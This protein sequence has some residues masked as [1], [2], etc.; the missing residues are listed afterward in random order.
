MINDAGIS[1]VLTQPDLAG[2]LPSDS[3]QLIVDRETLERESGDNHDVK[4]SDQ[5]LAYVLYTSG[6]TGK[7]K[8]VEVQHES[9]ATYAETAILNFEVESTDRVLQFASISFDTSAEEIYSCLLS[10][11]TLVL[12]SDAML[13]SA[14]EFFRQCDKWNITV[15]DL[16]TAYW[17]EL[18][19]AIDTISLPASLRLVILGGEKVRP[20]YVSRWRERCGDHP[21]LCNTYGP[22]EATIVA[23]MFDFAESGSFENAPIGRPIDHARVRVL[24]RSLRE[25]PIGISGELYIGGAGLARGYRNHP[26]LTAERF[27]PDPF[28]ES[29][30]RLYKSGDVVRWLPDGNLDYV[31]RLDKQ[32][33]IRGFRVETGEI[34]TTLREH[35]SVSDVVVVPR[36]EENDT[37]LVAYVLTNGDA[38]EPNVLRDFLRRR[39]PEHMIPSAFVQLES[40]PLTAHGKVDVRALPAPDRYRSEHGT[41]FVAP[42]N[43]IE[44]L[45]AGIWAEVLDLEEVGIA[46]NFFDV[47]GHS[48][49]A[50][51][52]I[53]RIREAL[54]VELPLRDIFESS[55]VAGLAEKVEIALHTD[56]H[57]TLP[58]IK[59]VSRDQE[60]PLSF[61]KSACGS[62]INCTQPALPTMCSGHCGSQAI[63]TCKYSN[64]RLLKY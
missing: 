13:A 64:V 27:V 50:T 17:H 43:P 23:T 5:N 8:A 38:M 63:S 11:A 15:L 6:S 20:E 32:V 44:T 30:A 7:P 53:S 2:R 12:R 16:P 48:L 59:P 56:Q 25:C 22:T 29:G 54:H 35:S 41:A 60:L 40:I 58:S 31:E 24:D 4:T 61:P 57:S 28:G 21:R 62:C 9:L 45:I 34:E 51:Q 55:T 26:E 14:A 37:R 19:N 39:L 36:T 49:L 10:G 1:I 33:K 42:R 46:N 3:L 18:V 47:G 52:V